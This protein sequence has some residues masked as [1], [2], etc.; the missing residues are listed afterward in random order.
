MP[1]SA[2]HQP[3]GAITAS[4]NFRPNGEGGLTYT[5]SRR[6]G[7]DEARSELL[8]DVRVLADATRDLCA[9]H[10][11]FWPDFPMPQDV[12]HALLAADYGLARVRGG[13]LKRL[14]RQ[15]YANYRVDLAD[16]IQIAEAAAEIDETRQFYV[17]R[18]GEQ[19]RLAAMV[20]RLHDIAERAA[21]AHQ[22]AIYAPDDGSERAA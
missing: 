6:S 11:N 8:A 14:A 13:M 4:G 15:D 10:R 3:A 5:P 9:A 2:F 22:D 19:R 17:D 20:A 21:G 18:P 7:G 16:L 12:H 1:E